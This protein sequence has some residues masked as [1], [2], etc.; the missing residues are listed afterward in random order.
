MVLMMGQYST[1]K[2]TFIRHLLGDDYPGIQIGPEPTTDRFVAV[3]HGEKAQ[4]I[5][6]H[7]VIHDQNLPFAPLSSYGNGFLS[8]MDCAQLPNPIL[9]GVTFVDTPGMLSG[10]RQ[11]VKR[12][13][14][15]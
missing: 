4:A 8:R 15:Y 2:T 14:D 1:G 11:R 7:A 3:C 9:E 10:D 6:G 12:G 5:P 13:Y